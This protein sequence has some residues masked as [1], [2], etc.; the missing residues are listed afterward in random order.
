MSVVVDMLKNENRRLDALVAMYNQRIE[1][2]P[3]GSLTSKAQGGREYIYLSYREGAKVRTDYLGK[4]GA[5]RVDEVSA[6]I[7]QRRRYEN[8]RRKAKENLFEVR[9]LLR[10]AG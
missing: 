2:L 5:S 3:K 8:F 7:D 4:K 1:V 9:K 6:L 10:A